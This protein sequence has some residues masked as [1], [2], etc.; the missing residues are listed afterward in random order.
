LDS[1]VPS[2]RA[3]S[4]AQVFG[5]KFAK[6]LKAQQSSGFAVF[7]GRAR[8]RAAA[9]SRAMAF[10]SA[11]VHDPRLSVAAIFGAEF[12]KRLKV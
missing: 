9:E 12:A 6:R 3:P 11:P 7:P 10:D 2:H 8:E 1:R 4:V 5:V